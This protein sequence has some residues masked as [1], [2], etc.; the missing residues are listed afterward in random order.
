MEGRVLASS[1]FQQGAAN[2][3]MSELM[4]NNGYIYICGRDYKYRPIMV[5]KAFQL[6][7]AEVDDFFR[8]TIY[9]HEFAINN[10][11]L[12]GQVESWVTIYDLGN[13]G[14]TDIPMSAMKKV[15]GDLSANYSGRLG[16]MFIVNAPSSVAFLWKM[17]QAFLSDITTNK[18]KLSEDANVAKREICDK[19]QLEVK[20]GG[21][22]PDIT[23][24]W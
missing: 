24:Y 8:A 9:A 14:L 19:N 3:G 6:N 11:F 22:Q 17:V 7:M 1:A 5:V 23:V 10:M 4:Q 21:T 18:I 16:K 12:P 15:A 13:T 2:T 20:Y